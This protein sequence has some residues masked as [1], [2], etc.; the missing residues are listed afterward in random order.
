MRVLDG[1][2]VVDFTQAYSGPY[3]TMQLADFGARVIKIERRIYGDQ[4]RAWMPL[5]EEGKSGYYAVANR[6]KES[7]ALDLNKPEAV[8][9][10]K[11]LVMKADIVVE[12]FKVGTLKKLGMG[13]EDL[14]AVNPEIIYASISGFGQNGEWSKY[15][16]Y[17]N[18]IQA[19]CGIMTVTG[20]E[21]GSPT[22]IGPAI[23]DNFTG[24]TTSLGIVMAYYHKLKTGK[25]QYLDV[26]MLDTLFGILERPVLHKTLLDETIG[27]YGNSEPQY[28]PYDVYSCT[29]GYFAVTVINENQWK[30]F[31]QALN[32]PELAEDVRFAVNE[33]RVQNREDLN[34]II[35]EFCRDKTKKELA[36]M[37]DACLVA[38]APVYTVPELIHNDHMKERD[39]LVEIM[40]SGVGKYYAMGNPIKMSATP[41]VLEKG[42]PVL[43]SSTVKVLEE[44]GYSQK[45]IET[46]KDNQVI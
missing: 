45:D 3:S 18:V 27:R 2:T 8:E 35:C 6:G 30:A 23:G 43:G 21:D 25:G 38:N 15:A 11:K 14:K 4:S 13:Y 20:F 10:V 32:Q 37:F 22:K 42:A 44:L 46:L 41:P 29:D 24:L 36:E 19:T 31:C 12:N 9:I 17:D 39:M 28:A 16:A 40:D 5:N 7:I 26:S 34:T 1:V 33:A